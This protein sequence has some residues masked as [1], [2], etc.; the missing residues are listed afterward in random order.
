M[1]HNPRQISDEALAMLRKAMAEF[2]D[3]SGIVYNQRTKDEIRGLCKKHKLIMME[4][5][6]VSIG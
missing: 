1:P 3:L 4:S 6:L 5:R 2:G